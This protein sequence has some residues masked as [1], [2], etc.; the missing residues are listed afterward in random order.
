MSNLV[1]RIFLKKKCV[2]LYTHRERQRVEAAEE[3]TIC[4]IFLVL[5][6]KLQLKSYYV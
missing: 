1:G 2:V 4:G 3:P 6:K 5:E